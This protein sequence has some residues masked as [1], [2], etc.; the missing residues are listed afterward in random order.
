MGAW[1][2]LRKTIALAGLVVVPSIYTAAHAADAPWFSRINGNNF[3]DSGTQVAIDKQ[4]NAIVAAATVTEFIGTLEN[5]LLK[6]DRSGALIWRRRIA[7]GAFQS[8][9]SGLAVDA[10]GNIFLTGVSRVPTD[11]GA[12]A[13]D[14]ESRTFIV[15]FDPNGVELW[16][17]TLEE[18]HELIN[19]SDGLAVDSQGNVVI[20]ATSLLEGG[21]YDFL[22]AK[23]DSEGNQL[24]RRRYDSPA[25]LTD[26][27]LAIGVDSSSNVY[28]AG[29][30][31]GNQITRTRDVDFLTI[32]YSAAGALMWARR[33]EAYTSGSQ[34]HVNALAVSPVGG[35]AVVGFADNR[36]ALEPTAEDIYVVKYDA[37]GNLAWSYLRN[38]TG[39]F[40]H[41]YGQDIAADAQG[42]IHAVGTVWETDS[43]GKVMTKTIAI[44]VDPTGRVL[45]ERTHLPP[46][47]FSAYGKAV[48]VDTFGN[49]FVGGSSD[50]LGS[51]PAG[52]DYL[53][54]KYSPSGAL[55]W[56]QRYDGP[57]SNAD[58][59]AD[60]ATDS[61]GNVVVT[62]G[63]FG[64][65]TTFADVATLRYVDG[66][67]FPASAPQPPPLPP[68][69]ERPAVNKLAVTIGSSAGGLSELAA[70]DD[71][72]VVLTRG[73][74]DASV[75]VTLEATTRYPAPLA[76]QTRM[77]AAHTAGVDIRQTIEYFN[78]TTGT[79]ELISG[80]SAQRND[81]ATTTAPLSANNLQRFVQQGTGTIRARVT[82]RQPTTA[83]TS[84]W[85][86][87]IDQFDWY[88][89]P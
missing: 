50:R 66:N 81:V 43:A 55:L 49:V 46:A 20:A 54:L 87:R 60:I 19:L 62:G 6:Y 26:T 73:R 29:N 70:A 51:Y 86:A 23:Y 24:W 45:W 37:A 74:R 5:L 34:E 39:T 28:V 22:T 25:Q 18:P 76:L 9:P 58:E 7:V 10:A 53:T 56:T 68:L 12:R 30:S 52:L 80:E 14:A 31:T 16:R 32:K 47:A 88:V 41:D 35:V 83:R 1:Q 72:Y 11:D 64:G 84:S 15:K 42:N 61:N 67:P 17:R 78:F 33:A 85:Q 27:A 36:H 63:S 69:A 40:P 75:Q 48:T 59:I 4:G 65:F 57:G 71:R 8:K 79:Y 89:A 2:T 3:D 82:F 38:G 13:I 21:S 77:E 44:K